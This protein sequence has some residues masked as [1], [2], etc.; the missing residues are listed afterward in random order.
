MPPPSLVLLVVIIVTAVIVDIFVVAVV[1]IT[2]V[3]I[4][5]VIIQQSC[6]STV[7]DSSRMVGWVDGQFYTLPDMT[8]Q[9]HVCR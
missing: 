6:Q 1:L 9:R 2:I 3:T 7:Q 8:Q 4:V 5:N